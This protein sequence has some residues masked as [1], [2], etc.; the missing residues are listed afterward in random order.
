V[1]KLKYTGYE[2]INYVRLI[3][4]SIA[5]LIT[6]NAGVKDLTGPV[7]I[8]DAV[9]NIGKT[10]T[11]VGMAIS[12]IA[13]FIAFIG[14][15]IAFVNLLPIPA[16]DGGRILFTFLSWLIEKIIRRR[17]NPKYEGYIHTGVL[18]LLMGF[19]VFILVN[20]VLRIVGS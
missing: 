15:N 17:L 14:I 9:N 12:Q 11:S 18:V 5:Q 7:G 2:A 3:R 1:E 10:S 4:V 13:D 8:V 16:M 19:M 20:D 6:G